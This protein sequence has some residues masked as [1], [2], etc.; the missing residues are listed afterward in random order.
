[1]RLIFVVE[2]RFAL[3]P[4]IAAIRESVDQLIVVSSIKELF[5]TMEREA[6]SGIFLDVPSLVRATKDD[7]AALYD[8]IHIFPTLRVKWDHRNSTVR[9]LFYDSVPGPD[10]GVETFVRE[11]CAGFLPRPTRQ[12]ER[13]ALQLN[14][15]VS[16]DP[17]F[18]EGAAIKTATLNLTANGCFIIGT[19]EWTRG[20]RL[21]V[22]MP[23]L[24][25]PAPIGVDVRWR[26][27]WNDV[28]GVPGAGV[29]FVEMRD[30]QRAEL[31]VF[32]VS[33]RV[34]SPI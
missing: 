27:E 17:S 11:Q 20:R 24:S 12:S 15:L 21:W 5:A 8:L 2:E 30:G 4:Y 31:E 7:K 23:N 14:I 22:K 29:E 32:C 18:P 3:E 6:C 1:M 33:G 13:A 34:G 19:G 16:P 26:K 9:A 25:D 28:P 10:A